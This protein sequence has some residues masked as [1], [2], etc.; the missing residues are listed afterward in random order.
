MLQSSWTLFIVEALKPYPE[1]LYSEFISNSIKLQLPDFLI[2]S[3]YETEM[4]GEVQTTTSRKSR[5][6][7][8]K[9]RMINER[10]LPQ[11]KKKAFL[12]TE[13][14]YHP[15]IKRYRCRYLNTST[16][17]TRQ[18]FLHHRLGAKNPLGHRSV[19]SDSNSV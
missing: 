17:I 4:W 19:D 15:A 16:S 6:E 13:T 2:N 14:T 18:I 7:R 10:S 3:M 8:R 12:T 9:G 5:V 1:S 11:K